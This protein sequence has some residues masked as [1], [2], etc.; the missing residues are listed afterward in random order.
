MTDGTVPVMA[1]ALG[2]L[3]IDIGF[4]FVLAMSLFARPASAY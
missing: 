2:S 4:G 3:L 1:G